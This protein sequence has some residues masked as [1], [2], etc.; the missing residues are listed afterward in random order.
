MQWVTAPP[1]SLVRTMLPYT[2][3]DPYWLSHLQVG[4]SIR[5]LWPSAKDYLINLSH[6]ANGGVVDMIMP[7]WQDYALTIDRMCTAVWAGQA[8]EEALEEGRRRVGCDHPTARRRRRRRRRMRSSSSCRGRTADHT[9]EKLGMAVIRV[10]ML[11][12]RA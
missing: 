12:A 8:P 3:R 1:L 7:G 11:A 6:S 9:I 5:S 10:G 4:D 2:L